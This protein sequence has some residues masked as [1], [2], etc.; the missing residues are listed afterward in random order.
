MFKPQRDIS[1]FLEESP[2]FGKGIFLFI[3][4]NQINRLFYATEQNGKTG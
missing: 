2:C 4:D 1:K 3:P